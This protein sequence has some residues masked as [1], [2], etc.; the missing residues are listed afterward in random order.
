MTTVKVLVDGKLACN[1]E[2]TLKTMAFPHPELRG[3]LVFGAERI[4]MALTCDG[5][6]LGSAKP[7]ISG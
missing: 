1:A 3:C 4:G 6:G 7:D 5:K 2:L